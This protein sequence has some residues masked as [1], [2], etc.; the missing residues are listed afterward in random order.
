MKSLWNMLN[1]YLSLRWCRYTVLQTK[2]VYSNIY[3]HCLGM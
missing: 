1:S 3:I 2:R